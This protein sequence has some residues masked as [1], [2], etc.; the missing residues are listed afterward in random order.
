M[1]V[2]RLCPYCFADEGLRRRI[3]AVRPEYNEGRCDNHPNRKGIPI[4]AVAKI[5][6]EVLRENFT[7]GDAD[8]YVG[9][10]I[11]PSHCGG[12]RGE[13][14]STV[15]SEL[16]QAEDEGTVEALVAQLIEDDDYWPPDGE[17]PFYDEGQLYVRIEGADAGHGARWERFCQTVTYEQ[18]FMNLEV[19]ELL[20][21]IFSNIHLQRDNERNPVV[22]VMRPNDQRR[23]FRARLASD[24]ALHRFQQDPAAE[25][26]PPPGK[27]GKPNRMNPSGISALYGAFDLDTCV[28]ELRPLV[29]SQVVGAEFELLREILVLD[30]TRFAAPAKELNLFAKDHLRRL[31]QWR[32]MQRFMTEIGRPISPGDEHLEYVPTQV[33]AEYLNRVH[34]VKVSGEE[35][36]IEA[37]LYRSAQRPTGCNIV[38]LGEA[39]RVRRLAHAPIIPALSRSRLKEPEATL[40]YV[41][42]SLRTL[43]VAASSFGVERERRLP[44]ISPD[45]SSPSA[46]RLELDDLTE[47]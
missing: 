37:I 18:R 46:D 38:F 12:Q 11:L 30:T 14:L 33:V 32:F 13:M 5:V 27:L 21:D 31:S 4:E 26:G 34:S 8:Y 22:Y 20:G 41:D 19:R 9:A 44:L 2:M 23:I 7:Y 47:F 1:T 43:T 15:V 35:R 6:D 45:S 42:G 39:S 3:A 36:Q 25:L 29:G 24:E 10:E 17:E 16:T 28:S 40:A